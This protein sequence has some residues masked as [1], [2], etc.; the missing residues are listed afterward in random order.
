[1]ATMINGSCISCGACEPVCPGDGI[2][3]LNGGYVIDSA[4]CMECV[5]FHAQQ[6]CIAVCPIEGCCIPDPERVESEEVLFERALK[7]AADDD[8]LQPTLAA[9]TSHFR[10][11]SL[12]WWKR[13][14][15]SV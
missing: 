5:G 15:L 8:D 4:R 12:P 2:R 1:M 10:A 14:L 3:K 11:S 13:L 7:L 9:G 6:Q